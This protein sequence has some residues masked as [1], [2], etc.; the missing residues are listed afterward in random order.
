MPDN[1]PIIGTKGISVLLKRDTA[2][3]NADEEG[4]DKAKTY[5]STKPTCSLN[6]VCYRSGAAGC[7]LVLVQSQ[8]RPDSKTTLRLK[9]HL[10]KT[11]S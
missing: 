2:L 5:V 11:R 6:L 3:T 1:D 4:M 8:K 10:Q 7:E 9:Q